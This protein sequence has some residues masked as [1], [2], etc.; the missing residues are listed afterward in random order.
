MPTGTWTRGSRRRQWFSATLL[1]WGRC[2][3]LV[4]EA[5]EAIAFAEYAPAM[6]FPRL[7]RYPASAATSA[8]AVYLSY[9]FVEEGHRGRGLG[10][11]LVGAVARDAA[12]RGY[13]GLEAIGDR[14]W[15][16]T[17]VLPAPFLRA[18]GFEV[19]REDPRFPLL[20][21]DL[22]D[23]IGPAR[24][25]S[26]RRLSFPPSSRGHEGVCSTGAGVKT[27]SMPSAMASASSRRDDGSASSASSPGQVMKQTST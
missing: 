17:W 2:G 21:L 19:V 13:Q 10:R 8:D 27:R 7:V 14:E 26:R 4:V 5:G 18:T 15:D 6:L 1:E 16:G 22:D 20:R 3:K 12:E 9:C 24:A 23:A 11:E 25:L